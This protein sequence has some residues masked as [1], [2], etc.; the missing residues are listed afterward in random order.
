[1]DRKAQYQRW[2]NKAVAGLAAQGFERSIS[3]GALCMYRGENGR[4]CGIGQL[5]PNSSYDPSM[6][7]KAVNLAFSFV[8]YEGPEVDGGMLALFL[9]LADIGV[10][11]MDDGFL[12]ALQSAHDRGR[13]PALMRGNLA[14]VAARFRLRA[15]KVL[16]EPTPA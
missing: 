12:S 8:E 14:Y 6:E 13:N 9:A 4:K 10:E 5:I 15:P 11:V 2:F 3:N 1:M 16:A 7:A